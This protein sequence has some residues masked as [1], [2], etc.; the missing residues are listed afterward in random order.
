MKNLYEI[1]AETPVPSSLSESSRNRA[2]FL[3]KKIENLYNTYNLFPCEA[4]KI[5]FSLQIYN[6]IVRLAEIGMHHHAIVHV[7]R[8]EKEMTYDLE[9][10]CDLDIPDGYD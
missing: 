4:N 7:P 1:I 5:F 3:E 10:N 6:S 9:L 8:F 2:K